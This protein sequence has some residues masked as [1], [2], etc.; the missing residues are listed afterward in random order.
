MNL[1]ILNSLQIPCYVRDAERN[2]VF[3]NHSAENLIG[4]KDDEVKGKKCFEIFGYCSGS[5]PECPADKALVSADS[6][7]PASTTLKKRNGESITIA[8]KISRLEDPINKDLFLVTI[9]KTDGGDLEKELIKARR[10]VEKA[11]LVKSAFVSNISHAIRTPMNSIIGFSDMLSQTK[12]TE[13]QRSFLKY[14]RAS[15]E[16]LFSIISDILDH[17]KIESSDIKIDA[18]EFNPR[19]TILEILN[20]NGAAASEKGLKFNYFIDPKLDFNLIGDPA[21]FGQVLSNL[22]KNAIVFSDKGAVCI[23]CKIESYLPENMVSIAFEVSDEGTGIPESAGNKIFLP[24]FQAD[25][26]SKRRHHGIGLGLT[27]ASDLLKIMGGSP[28][29][30]ENRQDG[31]SVFR[32]SL[33]VKK[34]GASEQDTD[35]RN[36][37]AQSSVGDLKILLVE[38]NYI[39]TKMAERL[40]KN[41]GHSVVCAENGQRALEEISKSVFDLVLMDIQMPIMDG[42]EAAVAIRKSG[43]RVPIIALTASVSAEERERCQNSGMDDFLA[44]PININEMSRIITRVV[45]SRRREKTLQE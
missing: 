44:K 34:A 30:F 6:F 7:S 33:N 14:I 26:S 12:L 9:E 27:I 15:G 16:S 36:K 25:S 39:N 41:I 40:L 21:R 8:K 3:I 11:N 32:F 10:N 4:L 22:I 38:D 35:S 1:S 24:F 28:I 5:C 29:S 20:I 2:L 43:N 13:E 23:H 31:G 19:Q 37:S 17:S 45:E 18:S 42:H